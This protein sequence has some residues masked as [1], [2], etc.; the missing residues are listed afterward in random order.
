MPPTS[1]ECAHLF[2]KLPALDLTSLASKIVTEF[3]FAE[4]TAI[5]DLSC[6]LESIAWQKLHDSDMLVSEIPLEN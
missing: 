1:N 4:T 6:D 3:K 5:F 2:A